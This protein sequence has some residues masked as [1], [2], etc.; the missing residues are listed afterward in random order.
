M[1]GQRHHKRNK[2]HLERVQMH[3]ASQHKEETRHQRILLYVAA[4]TTCCTYAAAL[5]R[6]IKNNFCAL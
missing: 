5:K 3:A 2:S 1:F 6:N 4:P